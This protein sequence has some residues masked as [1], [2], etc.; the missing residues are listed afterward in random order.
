MLQMLPKFSGHFFPAL[1]MAMRKLRQA[2]RVGDKSRRTNRV[3]P[4][5]RRNKLRRTLNF[6]RNL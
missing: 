4:K 5:S 6:R 2:N 3:G 1:Q